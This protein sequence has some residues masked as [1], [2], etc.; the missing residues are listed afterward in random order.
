MV[1]V[2]EILHVLNGS[3]DQSRTAVA[4]ALG[5]EPYELNRPLLLGIREGLI[6]TDGAP[7]DGDPDRFPGN[8]AITTTGRERHSLIL[9]RY[10]QQLSGPRLSVAERFLLASGHQ[11]SVG[12]EVALAAL[13]ADPAMAA[14]GVADERERA[15]R[16]ASAAL[17]RWALAALDST[18]A[19]RAQADGLRSVD[20]GTLEGIGYAGACARVDYAPLLSGGLRDVVELAAQAAE[21]AWELRPISDPNGRGMSKSRPFDPGAADAAAESAAA[22][23]RTAAGAGLIDLLAEARRLT[24]EMRRPF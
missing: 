20:L 3:G 8:Y 4:N 9:D 15:Q 6:S 17:G 13:A 10:A 19:S 2:I 14:G 23:L 1:L 16:L 7:W 11:Q 12:V 21:A 24:G 18:E 5:R 22:A